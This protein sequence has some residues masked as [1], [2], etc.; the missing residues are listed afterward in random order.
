MPLSQT[1]DASPNDLQPIPKMAIASGSK[2]LDEV[3]VEDCLDDEEILEEEQLDFNFSDEDCDGSPK[4]PTLLPANKVSPSYPF[5]G[6]VPD[7]TTITGSSH[8]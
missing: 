6:R 2:S 8:Q 1:N 5:G 7:T 4:S 3:L